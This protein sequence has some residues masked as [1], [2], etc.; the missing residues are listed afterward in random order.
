MKIIKSYEKSET[1]RN[2]ESWLKVIIIL[3]FSFL[4]T[5]KLLTSPININLSDFIF[6]DLLSLILALFAIALSVTFYFK[7]IET[8]NDFYNNTYKFTKEMSEILG[9]I[10]AGFGERLRHLDEGYTGL[11]DKMDKI[12]FDTYK[13]EEQ[14]KEEEEEVQKKEEERKKLIE[15]LANKAKLQENEKLELFRE[16]KELEKELNEAKSTKSFLIKQL[17]KAEI[18]DDQQE[19]FGVKSRVINYIQFDLAGLLGRSINEKDINQI[20]K[21]FNSSNKVMNPEF[22][23]DMEEIGCVNSENNLTNKGAELLKHLL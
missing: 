16:L 10:E 3:L 2:R 17:K 19:E 7:A 6:T 15:S 23:I 11:R 8:S 14:V 1:V 5:W 21:R 9:R 18:N 20:K 4:I 22:L 13:A 12:P